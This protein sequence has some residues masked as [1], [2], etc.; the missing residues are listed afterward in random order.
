MPIVPRST[1]KIRIGIVGSEGIKFTK[2]TE[3]K[4]RRI[5]R[6]LV[7]RASVIVSGGCHLGGIDIWAIE[8]AVSAGVETKEFLPDVLAW[9]GYKRRNLLIAR[10]C[11]EC[12]CIT[13]AKLPNT[14]TG[15]RFQKCY[16]CGTNDHVKS[17]GCWTV[18]Q[19]KAFGKIG[20]VVVIY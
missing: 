19:A 16:H 4:A 20:R 7:E 5:I 1:K 14:Y 9:E 18:K 3:E 12:V 11:D 10:N 17:G 8:E 2:D 6:S 13:V 15:M